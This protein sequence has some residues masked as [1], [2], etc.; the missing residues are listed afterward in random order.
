ME[1]VLKQTLSYKDGIVDI[2]EEMI[3][4][5]RAHSTVY[6]KDFVY[7]FGGTSAVLMSHSEKYSITENIWYEIAEL[8]RGSITLLKNSCHIDHCCSFSKCS[9]CFWRV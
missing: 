9:L 6:H 7:V 2:K 4:A 5:R 1:D 3:Q 8:P